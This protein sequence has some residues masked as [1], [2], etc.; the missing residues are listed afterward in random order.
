M[1][2]HSIS[3][4]EVKERFMDPALHSCFARLNRAGSTFANLAGAG[5]IYL[6]FIPKY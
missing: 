6:I 4:K 5:E 2:R 1:N 3:A